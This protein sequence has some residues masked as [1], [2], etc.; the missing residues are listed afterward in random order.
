MTVKDLKELLEDIDENLEVV[1]WTSSGYY[2]RDPSPYSS[3]LLDTH[4][5][6]RPP[7]KNEKGN[8]KRPTGKLERYFCI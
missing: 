1:R 7:A 5:N 4:E 3:F 6:I 8:P 2:W